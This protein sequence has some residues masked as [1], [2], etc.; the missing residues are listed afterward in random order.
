MGTNAM[1]SAMTVAVAALTLFK[2]LAAASNALE[3]CRC[4]AGLECWT[5]VPWTQLNAS[6]GGRLDRAVDPMTP[7][8]GAGIT[9]VGCAQVLS[10]YDDEFWIS[11][12]PNGYQH[13]GL[14][15]TW[16]ITSS[17]SDFVVRAETESDIQATV[18][19]AAVHNLR[20]VVKNTGHDWFGRSTGAGSLM[21]WTHKLKQITWHDDFTPS[22]STASIGPAVTVG[23]GIQFMDLYPE[24]NLHP[25]PGDPEGR[26]SLVIGG[27][28]DSVGVAG[29]WLGGCFGQFSKKYGSGAVNL[30]EARVVLAN[31]STVTT[32][33]SDYPDLFYSLRGGGGGNTGVVAEFTAKVHPAPR[34]VGYVSMLATA[35]TASTF[36]PL[37]KMTLVAIADA[38]LDVQNCG[39]GGLGIGSNSDG[40]WLNITCNGYEADWLVQNTL[41]KK[42]L[43]YAATHAD[44]GITGNTSSWTWTQAEYTPDDPNM[45]WME[46]HPDREISMEFIGS[47]TKW[48]PVRGI[49]KQ[50]GHDSL[51]TMTSGIINA[52]DIITNN[53]G[54]VEFTNYVMLAK[55]QTGMA[56][57]LVAVFN[58][59][60]QNPVL[61]DTIGLWAPYGNIPAIPQLKPSVTLLKTIWPRF[62]RYAV[63]SGSDPLYITCQS[64]A[65]GNESAAI[66]C[67]DAWEQVRVPQL[68]SVVDRLR[69]STWETFPNFGSDGQPYS[70]SYYNEAD[71][72]DR[73][74][75]NSNWGA[76]VY[77]K[78]LQIKDKYDPN[79]LFYGWHSV[80]SERWSSNG[81]CRI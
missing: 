12:Q 54:D 55:S 49:R 64:G 67:L 71:Y 52:T 48:W 45:P 68:L 9:S 66:E 4:V 20:L 22:R 72:W 42:V 59:T 18:S 14:Y 31:G 11:D 75:T 2:Q 15:N 17:F 73:N 25:F 62:R 1:M 16:N 8:Y 37:L 28:C 21:L 41:F 81:N 40:Y 77:S 51:D 69:N 47:L 58:N 27:T 26:K 61:L 44:M 3:S 78:L 57:D 74:F 10:S 33:E 29:C 38:I 53:M 32:S 46:R 43:N 13:V 79:G 70:G 30:V 19:F 63:L 7:C 56:S 65:E 35:P 76:P 24:A 50:T 39:D 60:P 80:G 34:W 23:A 5:K 6:V 36:I